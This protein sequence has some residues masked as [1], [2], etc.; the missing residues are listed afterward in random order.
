MQ[1]LKDKLAGDTFHGTQLRQPTL[2]DEEGGERILGSARWRAPFT[3]VRTPEEEATMRRKWR[4]RKKK[5]KDI[6]SMVQWLL[7]ENIIKLNELNKIKI[8]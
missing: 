1:F 2:I 8:A 4:K 7:D 5:E 6:R 3:Q